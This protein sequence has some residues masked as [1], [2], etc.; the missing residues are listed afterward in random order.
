M[1]RACQTELVE[2]DSRLSGFDKLNLTR[3]FFL[4]TCRIEDG[5][6]RDKSNILLNLQ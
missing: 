6:S 1:S 3:D 5:L 4:W 2:G